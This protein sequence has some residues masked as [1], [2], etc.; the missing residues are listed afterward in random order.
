MSDGFTIGAASN[1]PTIFQCPHCD[2][3][4]DSSA[5]TCRFCG[6]KVDHE[7]AQKAAQLMAKINQ[8]CSD[9][10][11]MKSCAWALPVFFL[12][13][14]VPF[15]SWLG[16]DGFIGLLIGIPVW[17]LRWWLKYGEIATAEADFLQ[18]RKTVKQIGIG[19]SIL[20]VVFL[21]LF[22]IASFMARF[23]GA[24]NR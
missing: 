24:T 9:A 5:E 14:Y 2:E 7:A 23:L 21:A 11:Y 13:R 16:L 18:A 22:I 10:S 3:T 6:I 1:A 20:F 4:I 19:G 12:L 15:L 8:G 17:A